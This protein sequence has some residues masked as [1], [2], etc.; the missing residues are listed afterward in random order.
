MLPSEYV[1]GIRRLRDELD[2]LIGPLS[3]RELR[4]RPA[5]GAWSVIE[6][7]GHLRDG[8]EI[9]HA[10]ILRLL[11]EDEP[12]LPGYD[13]RALVTEAAYADADIAALSAEVRAAWERVAVLLEGLPDAGWQRRGRHPVRGDVTVATRAQRQ[14]EHPRE[15]FAQIRE[16]LATIRA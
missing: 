6:I 11:N 1:A 4:A 8:A 3:D 13:E 16:T 5:D 10:R 7:A 12:Y 15:H 9:E 14:N 2:E